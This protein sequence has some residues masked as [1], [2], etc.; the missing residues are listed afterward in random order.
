M[1]DTPRERA[2]L[3]AL[4]ADAGAISAQDGRDL[5]LSTHPSAVDLAG[6]F[7][8]RPTTGLVTGTV[9]R[10]TDGPYAQRYD[11]SS[12]QAWAFG[13]PARPVDN[14]AFAWVNQGDAVL[15]TAGGVATVTA[16]TTASAPSWRVRKKAA[17]AT[18][19]RVTLRF[20]PLWPAA[21][22]TA[23][24]L[25]FRE[26]ATGKLS[27]IQ[28]RVHGIYL[29]VGCVSYANATTYSSED[30]AHTYANHLLAGPCLCLRIEDDGTN[31]VYSYSCDGLLFYPLRTVAR[32]DYFTADEV[33]FYLDTFNN[34]VVSPAT[35]GVSVVSWE[36]S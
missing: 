19:Y 6:P 5:I 23:V 1:P 31:R 27:S 17:P 9:H 36:E 14:S 18:P 4:Y 16:T 11:G 33:G 28:A 13:A 26:A 22:D 29:E 2:D 15:G 24:G 25:C 3:V 35:A 30:V 34:F 32:S 20:L 10:S 7:A 21:G 8:S 12:W